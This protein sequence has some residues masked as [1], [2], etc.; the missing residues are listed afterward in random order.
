MC[1][2][3]M[4]VVGGKGPASFIVD[5]AFSEKVLERIREAKKQ[6]TR[7]SV[8]WTEP[9]EKGSRHDERV[10]KP[11]RAWERPRRLRRPRTTRREVLGKKT[12]GRGEPVAHATGLGDDGLT[13]ERDAGK[14]GRKAM[15]GGWRREG[16]RR[17]KRKAGDD[18][19]RFG[20]FRQTRQSSNTCYYSMRQLSLAWPRTWAEEVPSWQSFRAW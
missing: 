8:D 7:G 1:N 20:A 11:E 18:S 10:E 6:E 17:E 9:N 2:E 3:M 16:S 12:K 13:K 19:P 5:P 4:I 15:G 14:D